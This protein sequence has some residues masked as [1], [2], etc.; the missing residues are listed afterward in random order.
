[1]PSRGMIAVATVTSIESRVADRGGSRVLASNRPCRQGFSAAAGPAKGAFGVGLGGEGPTAHD[2]VK[3]PGEEVLGK[4]LKRKKGRAAGAARTLIDV[5][6]GGGPVCAPCPKRRVAKPGG[7]NRSTE[8]ILI[9]ILIKY[10]KL[11]FLKKK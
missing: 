6:S 1:M 3:R 8:I 7:A 10:K 4:G 11:I 2:E 9:K 5:E